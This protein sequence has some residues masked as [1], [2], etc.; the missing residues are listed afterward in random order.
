MYKIIFFD[1]DGTLLNGKKRIPE[2]ARKAIAEL[3][4]AGIIPAI[5]TGRPPFRIHEI[6]AELEIE[7]YVSL[8]GQYVVHQNEVIYQNPMKKG[9][10][11]RIAKAA[12]LNNQTVAFCG[13]DKI[14]GNSLVS[15]SSKGWK[16]KISNHLPFT[17]PHFIVNLIFKYG[18]KSKKPILKEY[19]ENRVIYQCMLHATEKYDAYYA[20][21]FP[22]CNFMRWNP[23]SVDV[24]PEGGSKAV[25]IIK[26]LEHLH[27]PIEA[28]AAF[29]DGL[30]DIEMLKLVGT[31][32][33]MGNGRE[34][35]K[36]VA[37]KI[38]ESPE[39][40]GIQIGLQEIGAIK[41]K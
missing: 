30:N 41:N 36:Q 18:D 20:K 4:E 24:C 35:L 15:A 10:V 11:K 7:T 29:G 19:Y 40:N 38:T 14:L 32:I 33:A 27:I 3:K 31:G 16:K 6:L 2:S 5:A 25:G 1:I 13:S 8:N 22:D 17:P 34:E 21:E 26:L 37:D 9:A 28:S 23:Y 12:E 39:K